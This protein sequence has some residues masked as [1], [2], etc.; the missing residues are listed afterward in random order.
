MSA[1]EQSRLQI[2]KGVLQQSWTMQEAAPLPGV[3][4]R[5]GW[6]LLAAYPRE[7]ARRMVHQNLGRML[8]NVTPDDRRGRR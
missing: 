5:Q 4:G 8:P 3:S 7:G 2:L 1:K 6:R